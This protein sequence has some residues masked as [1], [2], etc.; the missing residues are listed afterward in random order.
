MRKLEQFFKE[1]CTVKFP[2]TFKSSFFF[3]GV[4]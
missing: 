4:S 1:S 3:G 2:L